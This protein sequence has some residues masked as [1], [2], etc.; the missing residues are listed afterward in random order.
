MTNGK[1]TMRSAVA[2]LCAVAVIGTGLASTN[3]VAMAAS[4][5]SP[6]NVTVGV[7]SNATEVRFTWS[8][9]SAVAGQL[10]I[11]KTSDVQNGNFPSNSTKQAAS[12]KMT[13]TEGVL[14]NPQNSDHPISSFL[15]E[16]GA[17]LTDEYA[18]KVTVSGLSANTSYTYR[19]G[20]GTTWSKNYTFKTDA[21]AKNF[22]FLAFGDPQLGASGNLD[23]DRAGWASTLKKVS[24]KYPNVNLMFS[25]GDQVNDYNHLY[26][27]Q[28]EYNAF[29]NPSA[30][31]DYLQTHLL[32]AFS[33]NHDFQMGKYYSF[34]YNQP[35]L[36]ALGQTKTNQV[37]DNNGDYWFRYGSTLFM[38]LE[39]NNFY[40]V[41]A[42]DAFMN[43]A[44][45][46]NK[47]AKWKIA[48]FH[49]APYSEANHDGATTADDDVMFMRNNWTKLMDKYDIDLVMNGHDHYYTRSYQMQA[50][51]PVDT[52]K[53][54][55]V[56]NPKGTV[57]FTLDSGS[58]S[59]YYKY[60]TTADHSF[61]SL[62]WQNNVPTYT[63]ANVTDDAFTL[64]TYTVNSETPIDT[65]T[66]SKKAASAAA[67]NISAAPV[68]GTSSV[69]PTA[70]NPRTGD[71]GN[72]TYLAAGI[73]IVTFLAAAGCVMVLKKKKVNQ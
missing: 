35:N 46:A 47:D 32:A 34:H 51:S 68:K 54:H 21:P 19:V 40:D 55:E 20:D 64:T 60:N 31:T 52:V 62:G 65:Y 43:Q 38:V 59:K 16:S 12:E 37:D 66:I 13:A 2:T 33:G 61:S 10:Q 56:T 14:D 17:A 58:G 53:T 67:G 8:S 23:N 26:T 39:G 69:T 28:K 50:G 48:T 49:Q 11:A 1:K 27:Q 71:E 5:G 70:S 24:A 6:Y 41:S 3:V 63:Y 73:A 42:H 45:A 18:N 29:F 30:D 36:S 22:S 25:L 4:A 15:D 7:G 57:Y 72:G 9:D 44:I